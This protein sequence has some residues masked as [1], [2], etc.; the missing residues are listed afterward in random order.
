MG[1][2]SLEKAL[3]QAKFYY[4]R[5]ADPWD[6][7]SLFEEKIA[8]FAGSKYAV[9]LDSCTNALFLCLKYLKIQN[10]EIEIPSRTYLS[11]PQ[12]ILH[13]GN[14]PIFRDYDWSGWYRLGNTDVI[15]SAGRLQKNMY[16]EDAYMC[17]S[18]HLRKVLPLGKG[19]MILLNSKEAYDWMQMAVYEGRDRREPHDNIKDIDINGWNMYMTPEQVET[20]LWKNA[21]E[22]LDAV[23]LFKV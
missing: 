6:I 21:L 15:D 1:I 18:F 2:Y 10:R 11:V 17:L 12:T 20:C 23:A 7:V 22:L 14:H 16:I 3:S 8:R 9:A 19:G 4:R 5:D 13:S